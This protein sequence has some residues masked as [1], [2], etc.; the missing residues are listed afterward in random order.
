MRVKRHV[1]ISPIALRV[2]RKHLRLSYEV[3]IGVRDDGSMFTSTGQ[4]DSVEIYKDAPHP[5]YLY[6]LH[7]HP[8][9][10]PHSV[11]DID[12][13]LSK[14]SEK[15]QVVVSPCCVWTVRKRGSIRRGKAYLRLRRKY[16]EM[17]QYETDSAGIMFAKRLGMNVQRRRMS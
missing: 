2:A 4:R 8:E 10:A 7:T 3:G 13:F 1:R 5:V 12:T 14:P 17:E 9:D 15:V 11:K 16:N 6:T